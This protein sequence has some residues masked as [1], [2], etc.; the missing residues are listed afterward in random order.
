MSL[1]KCVDTIAGTWH[2]K[3]TNT[4]ISKKKIKPKVRPVDAEI[5][6]ANTSEEIPPKFRWSNHCPEKF[7][8]KPF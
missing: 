6:Q 8:C 7:C 3:P 2:F 5:R 4:T 1:M